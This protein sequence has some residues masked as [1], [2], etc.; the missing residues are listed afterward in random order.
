MGWPEGVMD[1]P[2][3]GDDLDKE[4]EYLLNTLPENQS[5]PKMVAAIPGLSEEGARLLT[6]ALLARYS[7]PKEP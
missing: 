7:S 2:L 5:I 6:A 3:D 4:L 1:R